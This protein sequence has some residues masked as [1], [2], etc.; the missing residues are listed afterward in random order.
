MPTIDIGPVRRGRGDSGPTYYA[1]DDAT[2]ALA[3]SARGRHA[4]SG[5]ASA[6]YAG[7]TP[8]APWLEGGDEDDGGP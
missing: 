1:G 5:A 7:I 3:V 2:V 4:L 8:F 6:T